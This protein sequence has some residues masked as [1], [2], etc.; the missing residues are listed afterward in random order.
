VAPADDP[1][2]SGLVTPE[3]V[4]LELDA[5]GVPSR[6]LSAAVDF[7]VQVAAV[8]IPVTIAAVIGRPSWLL[9]VVTVVS[10]LLA[11]FAY[12]ALSET[13]LG[14]RSLGKVLV[15]LRVVTVEGAPVRFRHAAIRSA[16]GIVDVWLV[17]LGCIGVVTSLCNRRS[18]RL[19]DLAAG[20]MVL[21]TRAGAA[22]VQAVHFPAPV[23]L[24][25][26]AASLDVGSLSPEQYQVVRSY[27]LRAPS[28]DV[29]GQAHLSRVIASAVC[30]RL[31]HLPPP[32]VP[33]PIF[34]ACVAHAY[35]RR[36]AGASAVP[37]S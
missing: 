30:R 11:L 28:M 14:G 21:R 3:G 6:A 23:G 35:Q 18:Q 32:G 33:D 13:F 12:P 4:V 16:L 31:R 26:Y 5:A 22:T 37:G 34:L 7:I 36:M 17:P 15:G 27:L 9:V 1:W 19:G 20:T 8:L 24:E 25:G 29:S 2:G 10:V